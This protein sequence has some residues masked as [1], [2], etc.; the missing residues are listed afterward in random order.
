MT[1]DDLWSKEN[2]DSLISE[3]YY[4][5]FQ[6]MMKKIAEGYSIKKNNSAYKRYSPFSLELE[7][8]T[9]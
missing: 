7:T 5:D 2:I 4:S 9:N 1:E 8:K 6:D 3:R